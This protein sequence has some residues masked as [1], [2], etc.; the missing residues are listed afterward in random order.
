AAGAPEDPQIRP[1]KGQRPG[2]PIGKRRRVPLALRL[3][4][5]CPMEGAQSLPDGRGCPDREVT[6]ARMILAQAL[7]IPQQ[8][9]DQDVL[10]RI[11]AVAARHIAIQPLAPRPRVEPLVDRRLVGDGS[12]S[13]LAYPLLDEIRRAV[14]A[15]DLVVAVAPRD[16][17]YDEI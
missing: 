6:P 8:L 3:G 5:R 4:G 16:I 12:S 7:R 1:V 17:P 11:I 2:S 9:Q 15:D 13:F 14:L 10:L